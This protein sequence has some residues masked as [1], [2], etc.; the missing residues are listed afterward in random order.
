MDVNERIRLE[1]I[2]MKHY[3][4]VYS[5]GVCIY[6]LKHLSEKGGRKTVGVSND[7]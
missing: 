6:C 2:G 5:D 1:N 7:L 3:C 4:R